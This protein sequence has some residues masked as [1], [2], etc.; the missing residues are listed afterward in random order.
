MFADSSLDVVYLGT[1]LKLFWVLY[2][3]SFELWGDPVSGNMN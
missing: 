1:E 2:L 3:M